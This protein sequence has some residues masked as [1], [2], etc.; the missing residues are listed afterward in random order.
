VGAGGQQE[1]AIPYNGPFDWVRY[2]TEAYNND[3]TD[4]ADSGASH[5]K[6][7]YFSVRRP[8][9]ADYLVVQKQSHSTRGVEVELGTMGSSGQFLPVNKGLVV[10]YDT[11]GK[12]IVQD[13]YNKTT[14]TD[15]DKINVLGVRDSLGQIDISKPVKIYSNEL[16]YRVR[17]RY[18][19]DQLVDKSGGVKDE[20]GGYS[21]N[22]GYTTPEGDET[23]Q[24]LLDTPVF[25]DISVTYFTKPRILAYRELV[26]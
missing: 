4:D 8:C 17:F 12:M 1:H 23:S 20:R 3:D 11:N 22:S 10:E 19:V 2:N 6:A 14:F 25:D 9:P 13:A 5:N 26:E 18:P 21:V 7:R 15:P 24:Y 16:R